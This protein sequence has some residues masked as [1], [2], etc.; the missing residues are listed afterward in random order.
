MKD[1]RRE[2]GSDQHLALLTLVLAAARS[3]LLRP[4]ELAMLLLGLKGASASPALSGRNQVEQEAIWIELY[5]AVAEAATAAF[6]GGGLTPVGTTDTGSQGGE[7]MCTSQGLVSILLG[8]EYLLRNAPSV[9]LESA[10]NTIFCSPRMAATCTAQVARLLRGGTG[11]T[12]TKRLSEKSTPESGSSSFPLGMSGREAA[13]ILRLMGPEGDGL[14]Y[15]THSH[16]ELTTALKDRAWKGTGGTGD[17]SAT[18]A[19]APYNRLLAQ[20]LVQAEGAQGAAPASRGKALVIDE[21]SHDG[22]PPAGSESRDYQDSDEGFSELRALE[23][24]FSERHARDTLKK[25]VESAD[26]SDKGQEAGQWDEGN[27]C[28]QKQRKEG[29]A[30]QVTSQDVHTAYA[31]FVKTTSEEPSL[32]SP[33]GNRKIVTSASELQSQHHQALRAHGLLTRWREDGLIFDALD[34]D[35]KRMLVLLSKCGCRSSS[36]AKSDSADLGDGAKGGVSRDLSG[37]LL[38]LTSLHY[39]GAHWSRLPTR[40]RNAFALALA[41]QTSAVTSRLN[42]IL[43]ERSLSNVDAE[44]ALLVLRE[45]G[46]TELVSQYLSLL[47]CLHR[48]GATMH[49]TPLPLRSALGE[50]LFCLRKLESGLSATSAS[51][52]DAYKSVGDVGTGAAMEMCTK[53]RENA[54]GLLR[55]MSPPRGGKAAT[56]SI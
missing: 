9:R 44:G 34:K 24:S 15:L 11:N 18:V 48:V 26:G 19:A 10:A 31:A 23:R 49:I 2:S 54:E 28:V 55:Q 50:G 36:C 43:R 46:V 16:R 41:E 52:D 1:G 38:A 39:Y 33:G 25:S 20:L 3:P 21:G 14:G 47:F 13:V 56:S 30:S 5:S 37:A 29:L 40:P 6:E 22:A 45:A 4:Q 8:V 17:G 35:A 53:W 32:P 27:G 42:I 7:D 12:Y 51:P